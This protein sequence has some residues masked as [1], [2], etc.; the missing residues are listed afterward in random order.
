MQKWEYCYVDLDSGIFASCISNGFEQ[1]LWET[2]GLSYDEFRE[3][4]TKFLATL[5]EDG[6]EMVCADEHGRIHFKRP[7]V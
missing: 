7:K 1:R 3:V 4:S 2:R 6:W 5:G